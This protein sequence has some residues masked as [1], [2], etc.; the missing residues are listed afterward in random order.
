MNLINIQALLGE[1][2][3]AP[4]VSQWGR[5][6]WKRLDQSEAWTLHDLRRS[7]STKLNDLGIAPHVEQLLGHSMPELWRCI[8]IANI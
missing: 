7:F 5:N 3:D 6:I 8:T 2:K 4:A 1:S